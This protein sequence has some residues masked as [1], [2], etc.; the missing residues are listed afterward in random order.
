[1]HIFVC[2]LSGTR[3]SNW[4]KEH[5]HGLHIFKRHH[6]VSTINFKGIRFCH[7]S[8]PLSF[9]PVTFVCT[10][11][12]RVEK[13]KIRGH[14]FNCIFPPVSQTVDRVHLLFSSVSTRLISKWSTYIWEFLNKNRK[15][16]TCNV[17][18]VSVTYSFFVVSRNQI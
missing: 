13:A 12:A 7:F 8:P 6:S 18:C 9:S 3:Q 14:T 1:M 11:E 17:S 5:T 4:E 16:V 15:H 2:I 10:F